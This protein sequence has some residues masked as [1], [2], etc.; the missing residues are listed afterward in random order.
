M[1]PNRFDK[2]NIVK[3]IDNSRNAILI[4]QSLNDAFDIEEKFSR[5]HGYEIIYY[6]NNI[7]L[8][9]TDEE[10]IDN[11]FSKKKI[12]EDPIIILINNLDSE[13]SVDNFVY[14]INNTPFDNIHTIDTELKKMHTVQ[15]NNLFATSDGIIKN[16]FE[17]IKFELPFLLILVSALFLL[18]YQ[19]L[20]SSYYAMRDLF[21]NQLLFG[22]KFL[23]KYWF[24]YFSSLGTYFA[25]Y[26]ILYYKENKLFYFYK[27]D[28]LLNLSMLLIVDLILMTIVLRR[29]DRKF[30]L[31][32][33]NEMT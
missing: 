13:V 12:I 16:A 15:I 21:A 28:W 20:V 8:R 33:L 7:D 17:I 1:L 32:T 26:F 24:Y 18:T 29:L 31:D 23:R 6:D 2:T 5:Y 22:T 10:R 30:T 14:Y 11:L 19:I 4:P 3:D 25:V 27:Y 9:L